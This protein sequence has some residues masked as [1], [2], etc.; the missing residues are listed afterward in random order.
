MNTH[1]WKMDIHSVL[2]KNGVSLVP[3]TSLYSEDVEVH[4]IVSWP[5]GIDI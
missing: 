4:K 2:Q 5:H 1:N 3:H